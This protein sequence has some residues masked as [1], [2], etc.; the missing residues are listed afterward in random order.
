MTAHPGEK[1]RFRIGVVLE[2][3]LDWPLEQVLAW[4]PTTLQRSRT[5]R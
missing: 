3:F 5:W 4:L 2:A 1:Q